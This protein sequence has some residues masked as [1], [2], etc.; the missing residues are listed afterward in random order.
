M[1]HV[2]AFEAS[3]MLK[4]FKKVSRIASLPSVQFLASY[5]FAKSFSVSFTLCC[6]VVYSICFMSYL[7]LFCSR[8]FS[9]ILALRLPRMGKRES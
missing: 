6:F 4:R 9:V 2:V 1:P 3:E 7:V 5:T 8:V